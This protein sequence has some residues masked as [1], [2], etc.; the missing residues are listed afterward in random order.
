MASHPLDS[1]G[2]PQFTQAFLSIMSGSQSKPRRPRRIVD[3][4][5]QAGTSASLR[6]APKIDRRTALIGQSRGGGTGAPVRLTALKSMAVD[7]V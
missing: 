7:S 4:G 1:L 2:A 3:E 6:P 5:H